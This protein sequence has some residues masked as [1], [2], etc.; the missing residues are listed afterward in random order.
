MKEECVG[1]V[2]KCMRTRLRTYKKNMR[3]LKLDDGKSVGG[4]GRLTDKC[5]DKMQN[6]YGQCMRNNV[7]HKEQMN[8]DIWAIFKHMIIEDDNSLEEQHSFYPRGEDLWCKY[9][10]KNE[11]Y[12]ENNRLLSVF[13]YPLKPIFQALTEDQ[14]LRF[15]TS[16][17]L[18]G[19]SLRQERDVFVRKGRSSSG[20]RGLRQEKVVFV[21]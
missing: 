4:G 13:V 5:I 8:N 20:G 19:D 1:H 7:G 11:D 3:G 18:R 2:Q 16:V 9:W 21:S 14:A 10:A 15:P 6:F 12:H 17:R